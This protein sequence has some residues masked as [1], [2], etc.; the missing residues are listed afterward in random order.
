MK[1]SSACSVCLHFRGHGR[2]LPRIPSSFSTCFARPASAAT[3]ASP[4]EMNNAKWTLFA[5]G[6]QCVFAYAISLMIFQFG[7]AFTGALQ[8]VGL[9]CAVAVLVLLLYM[10]FRPY[11]KQKQ[12]MQ[13]A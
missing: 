8:P 1:R 4:G 10:L 7:S 6:Y 3:G 5:V 9:I 2:S 11:K 12:I 13:T